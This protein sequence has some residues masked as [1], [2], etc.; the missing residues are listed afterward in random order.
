MLRIVRNFSHEFVAQNPL[1]KNPCKVL[2]GRYVVK[3]LNIFSLHIASISIL[4][5][6]S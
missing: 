4:F 2:N 3:L 6:S 1:L 5:L